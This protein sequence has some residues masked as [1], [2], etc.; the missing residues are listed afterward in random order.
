MRAGNEGLR[1]AATPEEVSDVTPT[2]TS[3]ISRKRLAV[4]AV[5]AV[6]A[7]AAVGAVVYGKKGRGTASTPAELAAQR[8]PNMKGIKFGGFHGKDDDYYFTREG[9]QYEI[10]DS[11]GNDVLKEYMTFVSVGGSE[12]REISEVRGRKRKEEENDKPSY[13]CY[14]CYKSTECTQKRVQAWRRQ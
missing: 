4:G 2:S 13:Q 6:A 11:K 3:G 12:G 10:A 8:Q 14:C 1:G 9:V 5:A 7:V